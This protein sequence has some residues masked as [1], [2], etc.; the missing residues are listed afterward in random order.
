MLADKTIEDEHTRPVRGM[1]LTFHDIRT[2]LRDSSGE[3]I[4]VCKF[5]RNITDRKGAGRPAVVSE[6]T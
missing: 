2:P 6:Q 4:G 5:S 1:Y 3:V